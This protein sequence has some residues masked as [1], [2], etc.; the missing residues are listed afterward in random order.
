MGFKEPFD[1][2]EGA[3]VVPMELFAPMLRLF[4]KKRFKLADGRLTKID[5]VHGRKGLRFPAAQMPS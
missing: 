4:F 1:Q 3:A 5:Y 2:F